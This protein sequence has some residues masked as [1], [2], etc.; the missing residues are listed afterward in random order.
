MF[1]HKENT[2]WT[3][4][5]VVSQAVQTHGGRTSAPSFFL[6]FQ[7]ND[8]SIKFSRTSWPAGRLS[9]REVE[10]AWRRDVIG[11]IPFLLHLRWKRFLWIATRGLQAGLFGDGAAQSKEDGLFSAVPLQKYREVHKLLMIFICYLSSVAG[12]RG[13]HLTKSLCCSLCR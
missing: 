5:A 9:H 13:M 7:H 11:N 4:P 3:S 1:D 12:C 8:F 10:K 2:N 6:L